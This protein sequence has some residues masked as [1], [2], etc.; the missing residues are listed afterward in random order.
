MPSVHRPVTMAIEVQPLTVDDIPRMLAL[1]PRDGQLTTPAVDA[2]MPADTAELAVQRNEW[3]VLQQLDILE[4]DSTAR[5]IKAVDTATG[6]ILA[7]ARWHRYTDGYAPTDLE[8]AG[9]K[10]KASTSSYPP[11]FSIDVYLGMLEALFDARR[12]WT[13]RGALWFLTTLKTREAHRGRGAGSQLLEWGLERARTEGLPAYLE[14]AP[15]GV[16][17]YER[18]GFRVIGPL[19]INLKERGIEFGYTLQRMVAMP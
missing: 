9:C 6:E 12:G 11:G 3:S 16:R 4:N 5:Q 8:Y 1:Q 13:G 18:H 17:L 19:T 10:P 15:T 7:V 14:A 2:C